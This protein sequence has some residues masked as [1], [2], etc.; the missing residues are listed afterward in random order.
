MPLTTPPPLRTISH[1]RST[2]VCSVLRQ[3][4]G[5]AIGGIFV[6][7]RMV[8]QGRLMLYK[9]RHDGIAAPLGAGWS[10]GAGP[11]SSLDDQQMEQLVGVIAKNIDKIQTL[12]D[13]TRVPANT[14]SDA[15]R[16]LLAAREQL[17]RVVAQQRAALNILSGNVLS[18]EATDLQARQGVAPGSDAQGPPRLSLAEVVAAQQKT[19][20]QTEKQAAATLQPV[21]EY[22][23]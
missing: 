12:L 5:Q 11:A 3:Q 19:M 13:E 16:Q 7:D 20:S 22:C 2:I 14:A 17:E 23:R 6:N 10:G 4:V 18:N 21:I 8:D 1:V 9:V 15:D